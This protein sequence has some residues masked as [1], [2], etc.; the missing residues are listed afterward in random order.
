MRKLYFIILFV[1]FT[2]NV[3]AINLCSHSIA[4]YPDKETSISADQAMEFE[5]SFIEGIKFKLLGNYKMAIKWFNRCLEID[6]SSAVVRYEIANIYISNKDFDTAMHLLRDAVHYNSNNIWYKLQLA[7]VYKH[8]AMISQACDIYDDLY[9]SNPDKLDFLYYQAGLYVSIESWKNALKIYKRIENIIGIT[10][11]VSIEKY[12]IY[13][14]QNKHKQAEKE[15]ALLIDKYP[16]NAQYIALLAEIYINNDKSRKALSLF[17]KMLKVDPDNGYACFFIADYYKEVKDFSN[18]KKYLHNAIVKKNVELDFKVQYLI[19]LFV[20]YKEIGIDKSL[21]VSILNELLRSYPNE[22]AV[23]SLQAD[24]YKAEGDYSSARSI[25]LR[26]I[27]I[28][29]HNYNHWESLILIDNQLQDFANM[30]V[31]SKNAIKYFPE[32]PLPYILNGISYL[33]SED[34]SNALDV[35]SLGVKL[36]GDNNILLSQFYSYQAECLYNLK[37]IDEA[38]I[39]Y[40]K[41]IQIDPSNVVVLNNYSYYLSIANKDLDKAENMIVKCIEIEVDNPTYLDTYAWVL[42]MREKYKEAL[43]YIERVMELTRDKTSVLMEHYGDILYMNNKVNE[44]VE[45]WKE[46]LN[47]GKGSILLERKIKDKKLIK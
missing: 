8:K 21:I 35:L 29:K 42:Y 31:D 20:S 5:Y 34:Y 32:E 11:Q 47:Y 13:T 27:S 2:F 38:F 28:N 18:Y 33:V 14:K 3:R 43:F 26:I 36:V 45:A 6:K 4:L 16:K 17:E 15:I 23:L 30:R 24:I 19:K 22:I 39:L 7:N 9:I 44:A 12:K 37:R 25:L 46:A 41:V 1:A 10:E 40:D